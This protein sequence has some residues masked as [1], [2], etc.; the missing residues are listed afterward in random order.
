[1]SDIRELL[2][3]IDEELLCVDG[4]DNAIIGVA[5]RCGSNTV[6]AYDEE[7]IIQNLME[8]GLSEIDAI[9]HYQ[10]NIIGGYVG[11]YT[12]VFITML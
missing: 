7:V 4:H 6:V 11:E 12:P 3:E 8:E 5:N 9:E 1:L 10:F 2:S